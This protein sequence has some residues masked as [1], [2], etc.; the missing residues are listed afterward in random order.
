[1][2]QWLRLQASKAGDSDSIPDLG[3]KILYA[4]W[5]KKKKKVAKEKGA[6][7]VQRNKKQNHSTFLMRN[8]VSKT[9][10]QHL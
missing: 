10:K 8:N 5:S 6:R 7:Y 4:E 1:M 2:V 9:M 3:T